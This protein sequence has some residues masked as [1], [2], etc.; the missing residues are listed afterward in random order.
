MHKYEQHSTLR[1]RVIVADIDGDM[2]KLRVERAKI[3]L[4]IK[5]LSQKKWKV[6]DRWRSRYRAEEERNVQQH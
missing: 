6:L 4:K 1:E 5:K 3:S 2:H